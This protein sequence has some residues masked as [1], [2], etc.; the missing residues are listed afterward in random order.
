MCEPRRRRTLTKHRALLGQAADGILWLSKDC[1]E[2]RQLAWYIEGPF[3]QQRL[4]KPEKQPVGGLGVAVA[5]KGT[6]YSKSMQRRVVV[7]FA[8]AL[9]VVLTVGLFEI[10]IVQDT[11]DNKETLDM[12]RTMLRHTSIKLGADF[13]SW[14]RGDYPELRLI[15]VHLDI[16]LQVDRN[17][18]GCSTTSLLYQS[19]ANQALH[20]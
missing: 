13:R 10:S 20:M 6:L 15:P 5:R 2:I 8:L 9:A 1:R 14:I 12:A 3:I 19:T 11:E 16:E 18:F 7:R 4:S 17:I